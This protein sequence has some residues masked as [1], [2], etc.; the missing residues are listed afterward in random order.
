MAVTMTLH[1]V[2]A[3][4]TWGGIAGKACARN[5]GPPAGPPALPCVPASP[6]ITRASPPTL[7]HPQLPEGFAV[8]FAAFTDFGPV[9]ALAIAIHNIPEVRPD[10]VL[11]CGQMQCCCA[12]RCRVVG[13]PDALLLLG[14]WLLEGW[15]LVLYAR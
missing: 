5:A 11:W 8:A 14:G 9:M 6:C 7:P 3:Q 2:S 15:S 10:A 1:N 4:S 13:W 12:A